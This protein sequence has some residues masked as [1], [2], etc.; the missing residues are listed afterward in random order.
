MSP[1]QQKSKQLELPLENREKGAARISHKGVEGLVAGYQRETSVAE[2]SLMEEVLQRG[3]LLQ[4]KLH[5]Q[6]PSLRS[7]DFYS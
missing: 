4:A 1:L 5:F 2:C 6:F 3:N 7:L